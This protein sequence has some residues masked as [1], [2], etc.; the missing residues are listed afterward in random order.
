[1]SEQ[2]ITRRPHAVNPSIESARV[3]LAVKNFASIPGVCHIGLGVTAT[4]THRVLR[5]HGVHCETLSAQTS[6]ELYLKLEAEERKSGDR[7]VTHV[8]ISA[9][10]WVQ[11]VSFADFS[12]RWPNTEF[13]Q[14][15]HSGTAYLSIDRYGVKNILEVSDLARTVHNVR[16]AGNNPRFTRWLND[17]Y[18]TPE[19]LL[20]NLYDTST[21]IDPVVQRQN[22]DP[23]RVGSFGAG[24]PWKNQLTA[25][26][27]AV[28]LARRLNVTLEFHVNSMRPDGGE[29]MIVARN[30]MFDKLPRAT[31]IEVPWALWPAFLKVVEGQDILISPS[32]DETFCVIVADGIARGVPSVVTAA[33]EWTPKSWQADGHD[34]ASV[35][36]VA[37]G[38]LYDR[39]GAVHDG[40]RALNA[41]VAD[42]IQRWLA[43]LSGGQA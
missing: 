19:L 2:P 11:P 17:A 31:R 9:P 36:S 1:M 5:R 16:V 13:V 22:Y 18:G 42:G 37:M 34:P 40:R 4:N 32:H 7:P 12:R 39:V 43:Y 41:F 24:R 27:A 14:L 6:K 33:M 35:T 10:S 26:E 30:E 29:K 3:I 28:T 21:F 8:V 20:P 23:L 15:N 25:A 38:L